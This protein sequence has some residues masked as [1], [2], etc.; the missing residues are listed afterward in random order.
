LFSLRTNR[1]LL[2]AT[3]L[4]I[5]VAVDVAR[6]ATQTQ[7][8]T[9]YTAEG[10]R[11]LPSRTTGSVDFVALD[12]V[13]ALF[14]LTVTEDPVVNGL[15]IVPRAQQGQTILVI[16]GQSFASIGPGRIVSLPAAVQRDR[17]SWQVPVEFIRQAIAP[18]LNLRIEVRRSS[19][20]VLVGD[21]RLPEVAAR[22][23]RS[24]A[25]A[26]V[27]LEIQPS[28]PHRVTR[29]GKQLIVRFDAAAVDLAPV[30]GLSADFVTSIRAEGTTVIVDL[31]PSATSYRADD[32]DP[33]HLAI[34]LV[35][36]GATLP[37]LPRVQAPE[38]PVM[39][40]ATAGTGVRTIVIDPGHGGEDN[41]V[42]GQG[43]TKEKDLVLRIAQRLK[44]TIEG[45]YGLRVLL[46]RAGDEDV[47]IDKRTA[48]ANNNKA[49]LFVSL[50]ANASVQ[51]NARGV[52]VLSL[53]VSTYSGRPEAVSSAE[54][55]VPLAG[56]GT[57]T[58]DMVPWDLAQL[59]FAATSATVASLV[60]KHL[61][62]RQVALF[63]KPSPR[64]PLRPLV[65]ANM[66][67]V[68]VEVGFLTNTQDETALSAVELSGAI[69]DAIA[70]TVGDV[71]RG[72][73]PEGGA[74]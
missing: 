5:L 69:I 36:A 11:A 66:P 51:K 54:L 50:H 53:D 34:D 27:S 25:G 24:A 28:T 8:Y 62:E 38:P 67:A 23:E 35:T 12:Q 13:A 40:D 61:G 19:R 56:G 1:H 46:T 31:G 52:Q 15:T 37:V 18:A 58:V 30:T 55:P 60:T 22:V 33:T 21:V 26:R 39:I 10:R 47:P 70:D 64:L 71:R 45:R 2:A 57:R 72:L 41:G 68:M 59:P 63:S 14:G 74:E 29:E 3:V 65:G 16:P 4:A 48:L 6:P 20:V 32:T 42:V 43:G 49:D 7:S 9:V 17:G 73:R 44:S